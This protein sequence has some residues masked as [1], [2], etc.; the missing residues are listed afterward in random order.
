MQKI[1]QPAA[2][3]SSARIVAGP[4]EADVLEDLDGYAVSRRNL[5]FSILV[6]RTS[7]NFN[8]LHLVLLGFSVC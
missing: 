6:F 8:L 3:R 2:V 7:E 1:N 5:T 4:V